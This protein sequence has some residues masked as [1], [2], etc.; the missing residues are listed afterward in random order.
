MNYILPLADL[1]LV[2]VHTKELAIL[3]DPLSPINT[4]IDDFTW[5]K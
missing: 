4:S 3:D 5:A 2:F 1:P